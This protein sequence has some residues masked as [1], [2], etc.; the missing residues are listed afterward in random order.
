MMRAYLS[1]KP[2]IP[3]LLLFLISGEQCRKHLVAA[4]HFSAGAD[5]HFL[6]AIMTKITGGGG[7]H[8]NQMYLRTEKPIRLSARCY[9]KQTT[10]GVVVVK[11]LCY[12]QPMN[13]HLTFLSCPLLYV[14]AH[15]FIKGRNSRESKYIQNNWLLEQ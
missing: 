3:L 14:Q 8:E 9:D 6:P 2:F 13:G 4:S 11:S 10:I 1:S 15:S 5:H 12:Y 7:S